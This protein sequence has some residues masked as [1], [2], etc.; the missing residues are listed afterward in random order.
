MANSF[1]GSIKLTGESEYTKALK[2]ITSNLT[3]MASEMKVVSAQYS[4]NDKS[5]QALTSR[6]NILNKEIEEGKKKI[7]VYKN[8]LNDFKGQQE[9]NSIEINKLTSNLE[10]EKSKLEELKSSTNATS[11]EIKEQE[12]I[13][14][15][16]SNEL[17][18]SESQFEKNKLAINKYESQMNDAQ[19]EIIKLTSEVENNKSAMNESK[20]SYSK[21][22]NTIDDQKNKLDKLKTEYGSV[23]LEQGKN[24]KE[25]KS[26]SN[27]IKS[28]S[29]EI[30]NNESKLNESTKAIEKFTES[31]KDAGTQTLKLGDLIECDNEKAMSE[32][33]I[34]SANP[35]QCL[36]FNVSINNKKFMEN[37]IAN[38]IIL[39]T[40][41]GATGYFKSVAR[42]IF[43]EGYGLGFIC[44]TYGI[45]NI[46][47]KRTDN[48]DIEFIRSGKAHICWDNLI[49]EIDIEEGMKKNF[50]LASEHV[51]I[52]GYD[53]FMCQECRNNRN[54]TNV[55][56]KYAVI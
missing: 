35:T 56:D 16:L 12:K 1:G 6:N 22:S 24:S 51:S 7:D 21:L 31:E 33:Q 14:A 53:I 20:D 55:N 3:V 26:L 42:T 23:V 28:L 11:Q 18:K 36:R 44:P 32:I 5:V 54:S 29:N 45:N 25:A 27:E 13:V 8:A 15:D 37:V 17:A 50:T 4:N 48:V 19:A 46:V 49:K 39:S 10:K 40:T 34:I 38:G 41:I 47:L 9:K 30:K 43:R 2:T 52:F